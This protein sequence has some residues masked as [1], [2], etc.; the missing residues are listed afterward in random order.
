LNGTMMTSTL[1]YCFTN[2]KIEMADDGCAGRA[3]FQGAGVLFCM[4]QQIIECLEGR[5][6]FH[7]NDCSG[8]PAGS[9]SDKILK[10]I[11]GALVKRHIL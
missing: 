10:Q 7:G 4:V 2:S 8:T 6:V 1:L 3:A 5:G 9:D 11:E